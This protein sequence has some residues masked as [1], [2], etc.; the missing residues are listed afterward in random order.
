MSQELASK[1]LSAIASHV[2][3]AVLAHRNGSIGDDELDHRLE[4][5]AEAAGAYANYHGR[6][7]PEPADDPVIQGDRARPITKALAGFLLNHTH[8]SVQDA[9][10]KC[11]GEQEKPPARLPV[12]CACG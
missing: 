7:H 10:R 11:A 12:A 8:G 2:R 5:I 6:E 3:Q 9:M 4:S 1:H